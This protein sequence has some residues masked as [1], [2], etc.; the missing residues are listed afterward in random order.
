MFAVSL[1]VFSTTAKGQSFE[2]G[3]NNV[4]LGLGFPNI[5]KSIYDLYEFNS[6]YTSSVMLI[7][8]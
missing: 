2:E 4:S 6:G 5:Y 8:N 3:M 7:M 1:M